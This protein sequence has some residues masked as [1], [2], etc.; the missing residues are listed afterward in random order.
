MARFSMRGMGRFMGRHSSTIATI[1]GV[2]GLITGGV[3]AVKATPKAMEKIEE[4]KQELGKEKL[5]VVETV[6]ATWK[7]YA[8]PVAVGTAGAACVLGSHSKVIRQNASLIS[9]YSVSQNAL[10]EYKD[11]VRET[12]GDKKTRE[13]T[14]VLADKKV[15]KEIAASNGNVIVVGDGKVRCYDLTFGG[16]FDST[17][18]KIKDAFRNFND[19]LELNDSLSLNALFYE[20]GRKEIG[21]GEDLGYCIDD[22]KLV[23]EF[24]A[25]LDPENKPCLAFSYE[26]PKPNYNRYGF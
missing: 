16:Y 11:A 17:M 4:K 7:C 13:I 23:P 9:A 19:D 20:L 14:Q 10:H 24:T 12:L 25:H 8:A 26:L 5:T 15:E 2:I 3:L 6:Q 22:G 21:I 1:G 18:D